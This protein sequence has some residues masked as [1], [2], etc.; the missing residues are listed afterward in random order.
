MENKNQWKSLVFYL[1][2]KRRNTTSL[3]RIKHDCPNQPSVYFYITCHDVQVTQRCIEM[4]I[5][6]TFSHWLFKA[7][8]IFVQN[9]VSDYVCLLDFK[10]CWLGSE[11]SILTLWNPCKQCVL[12]KKQNKYIFVFT[13]YLNRSVLLTSKLS[14]TR[15]H[16]QDT[17]RIVTIKN[18]PKNLYFFTEKNWIQTL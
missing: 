2:M 6:Q 15:G 12:F 9:P 11:I 10:N 1:P 17:N 7:C 16:C 3:G 4:H 5:W 14:F 8:Q 13:L 18:K